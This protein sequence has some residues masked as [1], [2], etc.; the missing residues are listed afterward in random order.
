MHSVPTVKT[1]RVE[2]KA[3]PTSEN[4]QICL[5]KMDSLVSS[6]RDISTLSL[7]CQKVV[8]NVPKLSV[9]V[10]CDSGLDAS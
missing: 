1:R 4:N 3:D 5:Y 6:F 10:S 9:F 2:Y 8:Q 7:K